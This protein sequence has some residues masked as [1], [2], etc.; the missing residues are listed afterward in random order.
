MGPEG[1]KEESSEFAYSLTVDEL[2][3]H[4]L[5][6]CF[7]SSQAEHRHWCCASVSDSTSLESG[8]VSVFHSVLCCRFVVMH[9]AGVWCSI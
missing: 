9:S 1:E 6:C 5:S 7:A 3:K 8:I 2:K 4:T